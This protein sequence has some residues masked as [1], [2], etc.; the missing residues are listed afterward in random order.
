M[1][2]SDFDYNLPEELIAQTPMEPR[3]HS[4]LL[5]VHR[6]TGE[7]EHRHF[8]DITEY[9]RPGDA[10][11]INETKVIPA[12]L[13]GVKEDTGVP[14]EVFLLRRLNATDWEALV[15]PGRRLKPGAMCSFGDGLLRCEILG[16]VQEIGGRVVRFH[17]EG[18]FEE[19]LDKLGEMPLP[20]YIHEKLEDAARYQTV[21]N[22]RM[23]ALLQKQGD[24]L[25]RSR[26]VRL[27]AFFP[28]EPCRLLFQ[29]EARLIG[30]ALGDPLFEPDQELPYG[31][32]LLCITPLVKKRLD[33]ITTEIIRA[34]ARQGGE[35]SGWDCAVV[36]KRHPLK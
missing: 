24:D 15:R 8:Y 32:T 18:V 34:A 19:L 7:V 17:Y 28:T 26:R 22:Q 36:P 11:V 12:R 16:N 27:Y 9:L 10:L 5:V 33:A 13:L 6:G 1:K 2:T 3:D 4:R 35:L 29:E 21:E 25:A 23:L 14:V 31:I 20:P 30:F